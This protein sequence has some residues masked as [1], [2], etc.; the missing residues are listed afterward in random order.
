ML[1][2]LGIVVEI[3]FLTLCAAKVLKKD[4]NVKPDPCG[5][6]QILYTEYE[7]CNPEVE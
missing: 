4:C 1:F 2:A 7:F 3:L 6:S 5:N